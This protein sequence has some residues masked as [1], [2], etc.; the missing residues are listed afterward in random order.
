MRSLRKYNVYAVSAM[1]IVELMQ[2]N[3][4]SD[5]SVINFHMEAHFRM[6]TEF[7]ERLVD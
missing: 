3:I 2:Q 5:A 1:Q 6:Y 4:S 7:L